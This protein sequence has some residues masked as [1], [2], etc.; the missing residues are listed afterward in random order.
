VAFDNLRVS[1]AE[2]AFHEDFTDNRNTW[3]ESDKAFLENGEYHLYDKESGHVFWNSTAGIHGDFTLEAKIRKVDGPDGQSYGIVF[4]LLDG[5]NYYAFLI[6]GDGRYRFDKQVDDKWES[7]IAAKK[8]D[9]VNEANRANVLR[10]VCKEQSFDFY[11]NDQKVDS[12]QDSFLSEGKIGFFAN[13]N[14]HMAV[15]YVTVWAEK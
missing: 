5:D 12:V 11:I 10:V 4:R 8:V 2:V 9:A 6:R 7:I 13:Q 1:P 15:D 3:P 14:V